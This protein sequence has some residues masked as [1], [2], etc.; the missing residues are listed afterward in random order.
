MAQRHR[1]CT[2]S[3]KKN[4]KKEKRLHHGEESL[5]SR[6]NTFNKTIVRRTNEGHTLGFHYESQDSALEE[7]HQI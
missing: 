1:G 2:Q 6:N 4:K 7:H 5:S 3:K